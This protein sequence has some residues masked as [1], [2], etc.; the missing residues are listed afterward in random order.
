MFQRFVSA[1]VNFLTADDNKRLE[2]MKVYFGSQSEGDK[3]THAVGETRRQALKTAGTVPL[4]SGSGETEA[5]VL[6]LQSGS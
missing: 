3:W 1:L 6:L 4:L 5:G 2:N